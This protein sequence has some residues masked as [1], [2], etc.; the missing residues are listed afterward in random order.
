[1]FKQE[2]K[3]I[4]AVIAVFLIF[5][6]V[7]KYSQSQAL[8]SASVVYATTVKDKK[9]GKKVRFEVRRL[10]DNTFKI[11]NTA[12]GDEYISKPQTIAENYLRFRIGDKNDPDATFDLKKDLAPWESPK[13][14]LVESPKYN[15]TQ[16]PPTVTNLPSSSIR[17]SS[18][19]SVEAS[20]SGSN[21]KTPSPSDSSSSSDKDKDLTNISLTSEDID[22]VNFDFGQWLLSSKYGKGNVVTNGMAD[23][24]NSTGAAS[25]TFLYQNTSEGK[26]LT[27]LIG[28]PGGDLSDSPSY[29][30]EG[31]TMTYDEF[32]KYRDSFKIALLGTDM[33]S[34]M[35]EDYQ[36]KSAFRVYTLKDKRAAGFYDYSKE[37][38]ELVD[39]VAPEEQKIGAMDYGYIYYYEHEVDHDK[40]SYQIFLA[41]D[42]QVYYV[43]DYMFDIRNPSTYELA[44]KDM[45]DAYQKLLKKYSREDS[46]KKDSS[47]EKSKSSTKTSA[48]SDEKRNQETKASSSQGIFPKELIGTWEHRE[49]KGFDYVMTFSEDGTVTKE[50]S[51]QGDD[52]TY[53][54]TGHVYRIESVGDNV[55]RYAD[56]DDFSKVTPGQFGGANVKYDSGFKLDGSGKMTSVVWSVPADQEFDYSKMSGLNLEF[57]K[58]K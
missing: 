11:T 24:I 39:P 42:G 15:K 55:Y 1:M 50:T 25:T 36:A 8:T 46:K 57:T 19:S 26:I 13:L 4:V 37:Y 47:S 3:F 22:N 27:R 58:V 33:T 38:K 16:Q 52:K 20:N 9:T 34:T 18:S 35:G 28:W 53:V 51:Y 40:P 48:K 31:K 2:K 29:Y 54:E 23:E 14:T 5:M 10:K 44:P 6:L 49:E 7:G 21:K 41:D 56:A 43:K 17:G 12:T 32:L 45:Q 30:A